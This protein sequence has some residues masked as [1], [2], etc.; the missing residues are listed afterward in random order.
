MI[1]APKGLVRFSSE[2]LSAELQRRDLWPIGEASIIHN[3]AA[4]LG[5]RHQGV[6]VSAI[7][8]CDSVE[9]EDPSK[10]LV[11]CFRGVLLRAHCG[12]VKEAGSFMV[13]FDQEIW[14]HTVADFLRSIDHYPNHWLLHFMHAC[15]IVGYKH[16]NVGIS[17]AFLRLY[18]R[19]VKKFHLVP[20]SELQLDA[21]LNA[22]EK[23]FVK[24][25]HA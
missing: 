21:R 23:T 24:E 6:L 9:R 19:L 8:G 11:R 4:K 1:S 17:T 22:D 25:Q 14:D 16:P 13:P 5:L 12:D 18:L 10:W 7:R 20:E 2:E 3:W 15:E